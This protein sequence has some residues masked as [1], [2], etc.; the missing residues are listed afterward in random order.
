ETKSSSSMFN[1]ARDLDPGGMLRTRQFVLLWLAFCLTTTGTC[2]ALAEYKN[3]GQTFIRDDHYL[4]H[5]ATLS[6]LLGAI[7]KPAW[8]TACIAL[9][10]T[11]CL[12][13]GSWY[14]TSD[15]PQYVFLIWAC[16]LFLTISGSYLLFPLAVSR[17]FGLTHY[18]SNVA[19]VF[20]ALV[21]LLLVLFIKDGPV[22]ETQQ[23]EPARY[24][25]VL[26]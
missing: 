4:A 21:A 9:C 7:L 26:D 2:I 23:T 20:S 24:T 14:L 5:V 10:S 3:F 6:S 13:F 22:E 12:T 1:R 19:V 15:L 8:G 25:H 18:M 11:S 16:V 17:S